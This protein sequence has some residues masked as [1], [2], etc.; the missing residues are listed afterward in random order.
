[1]RIT[2][3]GYGLYYL[4]IGIATY[5]LRVAKAL[6]HY[7]DGVETIVLA[8]RAAADR[9]PADLHPGFRFVEGS[10]RGP[11]SLRD[12]RWHAR[13]GWEAKRLEPTVYFSPMETWAPLAPRR[14]AIC[15]HDAI[16]RR[17]PHHEGRLPRRLFRRLSERWAR[18]CR[19]IVT[20]SQFSAED[21]ATLVRLPRPRIAVCPLWIEDDFI[22]ASTRVSAEELQRRHGYPL[23]YLLYVGGYA[24]YKNVPF[25]LEAYA[26][27]R[28][29]GLSLPLVLAGH[30]PPNPALTH[31][32]EVYAAMDRWSLKDRIHEPGVVSQELLPAVYRHATALVYP[33]RCEGFGYPPAEAMA[34]GT[35]VLAADA[36]SLREVVTEKRCRFDLQDPTDLARKLLACERDPSQFHHPF[37]A[38][39][40]E[41][42]GAERVRGLF[43]ERFP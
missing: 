39:F 31:S 34:V 10:M 37:P 42:A 11:S 35:P 23:R 3:N 30:I 40:T 25:L 41:R 18:G 22:G 19:L 9:I 27:A 26:R 8:P 21:L 14:R 13:M 7:P 12:L 38:A 32:C 4:P 5:A 29:Q 20:D 17:Y 15:I 43:R 6:L 16:N 36:T 24:D 33:S 1:M 28:G 2:L